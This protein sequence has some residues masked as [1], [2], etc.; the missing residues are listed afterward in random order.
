MKSTHSDQSA[1]MR[2]GVIVALGLAA[3]TIVE[4]GVATG[5]LAASFFLIAMIALAKIALILANFMH[6]GKLFQGEG[7]EE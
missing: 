6:I 3:L 7:A 4:F 2:L 1:L 5:N